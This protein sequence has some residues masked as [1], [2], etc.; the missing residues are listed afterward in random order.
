MN[1]SS[2]KIFKSSKEKSPKLFFKEKSPMDKSSL[3]FFKIAME[4]YLEWIFKEKSPW[5]NL[6]KKKNSNV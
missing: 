4:K 3:K 6:L 1:K 5:I 2:L